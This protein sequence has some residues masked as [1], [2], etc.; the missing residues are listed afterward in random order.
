MILVLGDD[1]GG[2]MWRFVYTDELYHYGVKGMRWGIQRSKEKL[3]KRTKRSESD[4]SDEEA[5]D[6]MK[7]VYRLKMNKDS[8]RARR[9]IRSEAIEKYGKQ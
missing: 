8:F 2:F 4:I 5:V 9:K 3:A 6:F 1:N 7:D